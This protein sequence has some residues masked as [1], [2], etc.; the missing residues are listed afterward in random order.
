[1]KFFNLQRNYIKH[2]KENLNSEKHFSI[3]EDR[4]DREDFEDILI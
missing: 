3:F 1:M 4:E 2:T